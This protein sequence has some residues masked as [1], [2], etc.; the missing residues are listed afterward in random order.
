[1]AVILLFWIV[2][3]II[4]ANFCENVFIIEKRQAK[5]AYKASLFKMKI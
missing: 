5:K 3:T 2:F 1:M 4:C